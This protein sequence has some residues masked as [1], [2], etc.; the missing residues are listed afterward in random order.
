[1]K[2]E[3]M[4]HYI[5]RIARRWVRFL[6][7]TLERKNSKTPIHILSTYAPQSGHTEEERTHHWEDVEEIP[8]KTRKQHMIIR[9]ADANGKLGREEGDEEE[10]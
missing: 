3:R 2:R 10:K 4:Q 7:A 9:R 6:R 1:M 8:N 5:A